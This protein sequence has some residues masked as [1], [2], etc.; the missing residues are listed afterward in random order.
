MSGYR[1]LGVVEAVQCRPA[2]GAGEH[3]MDAVG[4]A[5]SIDH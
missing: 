3:Y 5:R 4:Q 2:L 1:L